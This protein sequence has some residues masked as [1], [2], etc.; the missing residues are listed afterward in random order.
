VRQANLLGLLLAA[1]LGCSNLSGDSSTPVVIDVFAVAGSGIS[2]Q[3]EIGDTATM[4]ARALNLQGDSVAATFTWGTPDT[5]IIFLD[6]QT[7]QISGKVPGT[8]RV[9]ARSGS[10]ISEF[11]TLTVVPMA[12][13]LVLIPPDSARL[14][15]ADTASAPLVAQMDSINP[16]GPLSGRRIVYEIIQFFPAADSSS[17]NGGL[18][19]LNATTTLTG[20][21]SVP[22]FVRKIP[23]RPHPD[24]V[25]VEIRSYRPSGVLIPG[26]GQMF[27]VRFDP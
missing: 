20:Q 25:Y 27:I 3:V 16:D 1:A 23:G 12:D 24:S 21:P 7:G 22:V 5:G 19:V 9:Q 8:A 18:F 4:T 15:S 6:P 11:V 17:L 13:S 14:L 2:G 10:L 26:S